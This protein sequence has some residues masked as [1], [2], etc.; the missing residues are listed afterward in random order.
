VAA[1]A[2]EDAEA[3][4]S[5]EQALEKAL[6]EGGPAPTPP[7][8]RLPD[9]AD[10]E[11]RNAFMVE[12]QRLA[13]DR[14]RAVAKAYEDVLPQARKQAIKLVKA[15]RPT[16]EQLMAQMGE[17]TPL[18]AAVQAC[19]DARN[20]LDAASSEGRREFHDSRLTIEA[21]IRLAVT[22]G[23]PISEV[24]DLTGGAQEK[25]RSGR[26]GMVWGAVQALLASTQ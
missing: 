7:V 9:R 19:R 22:G 18:I 17:V 4:Q 21:F 3:Q 1:L 23:D 6:L 8:R 2:G 26:T 14:R 11:P 13:E 20:A 10:V 5:Y 16:I 24:L 25:F 15:A 12:Q